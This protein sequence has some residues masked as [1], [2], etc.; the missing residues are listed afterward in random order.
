MGLVALSIEGV[1][2][3]ITR[4]GSSLAQQK[5]Q[6]ASLEALISSQ[7]G[8]AAS[9]GADARQCQRSPCVPRRAC[10]TRLAMHGRD[11]RPSGWLARPS[12]AWQEVDEFMKMNHTQVGSPQPFRVPSGWAHERTRVPVHTCVS[13]HV[14]LE[15]R[16]GGAARGEARRGEAARGCYFRRVACSV[17]SIECGSLQ[18]PPSHECN[19]VACCAPQEARELR[20]KVDVTDDAYLKQRALVRPLAL[21]SAVAEL[22]LR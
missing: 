6:I 1:G 14:L 13:A 7:V 22:R 20:K 17:D 9:P 16:R 12:V 4:C 18:S 8:A 21:P 3:S 5:S 19:S 15:A 11:A 2:R 10:E